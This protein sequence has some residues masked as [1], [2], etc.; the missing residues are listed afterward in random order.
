MA[1]K[2][3]L[4]I[5][6]DLETNKDFFQCYTFP[7]LTSFAKNMQTSKSLILID[8]VN[9]LIHRWESLH[10]FIREINISSQ[11]VLCI[12]FGKNR[13]LIKILMTK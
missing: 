2:S 1:R 12:I 7:G 9:L 3:Y 4:I 5:L 6:L 13:K 10:V 8:D 11:D